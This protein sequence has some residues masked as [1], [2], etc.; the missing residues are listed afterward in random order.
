[1]SNGNKRRRV[2]TIVGVIA[3]ACMLLTAGA[4]A[5]GGAAYA[6]TQ[7]T[8]WVKAWTDDVSSALPARAAADV[9]EQGIVLAAV[10]EDGP[11]AAVGVERGDILLEV[12][13]EAVNSYGD[14]VSTL[15]RLE[16]GDEVELKLLHGDDE[17]SLTATLDE[18]DD[19][20]F[21]GVVPC[22]PLPEHDVT[23]NVPDRFRPGAAMVVEVVDDSPAQGAGLEEG[24]II[25]AVDGQGLGEDLT[26]A[27]AIGAHQPG[28]RVALTIWSRAAQE[29]QESTVELGEHPDRKGVAYLGVA[30]APAPALRGHPFPMP[31]GPLPKDPDWR[32][33]IE[34]FREMIPQDLFAVT[35][36][37]VAAD[38]PAEEAGLRGGDIIL[39]VEGESVE[40]P[41]D[42]VRS[43]TG[44]EPG[45]E[46][47]LTIRRSDDEG[48]GEYEELELLVTLGAHSDDENRAY[49]GVRMERGGVHLR[50][51]RDHWA[52]RRWHFEFDLPERPEPRFDLFEEDELDF[53]LDALP[54]HF[55]F[56]VP[57]G[58]DVDA[59]EVFPGN[60][61]L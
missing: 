40:R 12:D 33:N 21:L 60:Q 15:D 36:A 22:C 61:N 7:R 50:R 23:V 5:V 4:A 2:L 43:V 11:A 58:Y 44:K 37:E 25:L 47:T 1:M 29:E 56:D 13:G 32:P 6:L 38:S 26:L 27:D 16:P 48:D 20:A 53:D 39:A 8:D 17:R 31:R 54:D 45:D 19:R 55:E 57:P 35:V 41:N 52:P 34:R 46:L 30:Y 42:V 14:L 10:V 24:D 28:D 51:F 49:L 3:L 59:W 9:R 18:R